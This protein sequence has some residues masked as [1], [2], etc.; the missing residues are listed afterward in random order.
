MRTSPRWLPSLTRAIRSALR[1]ACVSIRR[2]SASTSGTAAFCSSCCDNSP[3]RSAP[4]ERLRSLSGALAVFDLDGTVTRRDTLGPYLWGWLWRHPWRLLRVIAALYA[5]LL[6]LI[7]PDRGTLKGA[8]IRAVLGGLARERIE[9]WSEQF[10][11]R[12][13]PHGL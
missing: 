1:C 6:Y 3:V 13:I 2:R 12:L 10:V 8:A 7:H 9:Q 5:P 11:R 4:P